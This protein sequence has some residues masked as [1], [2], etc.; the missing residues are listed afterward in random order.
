VPSIANTL[1]SGAVS[2]YTCVG[3]PFR[4]NLLI[5]SKPTSLTWKFSEI[6]SLSPNADVFQNNP[7]PVDSVIINGR[8]HYQFTVPAD[9]TFSAP[10]VY[11]VP[12]ILYDPLTIDGCSSNMQ[13]NLAIT[14]IPAPVV[15]FTTTFSGCLGDPIQFNGT[16]TTANGT[17][18][19]SYN[20]DFGNGTN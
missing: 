4:F 11:S 13:V 6:A 3:A 7:V 12:I 5:T 14:V 18:I 8:M 15:D 10:G 2:D 19:S 1:G 20:W 9:Y 17:A 16:A